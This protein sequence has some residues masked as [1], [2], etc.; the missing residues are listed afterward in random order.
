MLGCEHPQGHREMLSLEALGRF[1]EASNEIRFEADERQ[2]RYGWVEQVLVGHEYVLLGK[3]AH[4]LVR[5]YIEK[6][7]GLSRAQPR[8]CSHGRPA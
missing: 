8:Y 2:Q 5:R 7:T 3:A 1:V 6:M 4:G